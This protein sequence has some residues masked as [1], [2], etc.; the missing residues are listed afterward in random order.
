M[1]AVATAVVYAF[2]AV[3][4]TLGVTIAGA[5]FRRILVTRVMNHSLTSPSPGE[6]EELLRQCHLQQPAHEM[7]PEWLLQS[8]MEALHAVFLLALGFAIGGLICGMFTSNFK[9]RKTLEK[10]AEP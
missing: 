5:L 10:K 7:C 6:V 2:R 9:L 3:G 8:Y 4:A 1:Q